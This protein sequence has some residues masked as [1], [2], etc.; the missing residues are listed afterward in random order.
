MIDPTI[1]AKQVYKVFCKLSA[2]NMIKK[3]GAVVCCDGDSLYS[4]EEAINNFY[5]AIL[6]ADDT[7]LEDIILN[8]LRELTMRQSQI[9]SEQLR[10]CCL[11]Q[12]SVSFNDQTAL[13]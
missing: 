5:R 10:Q 11:Q 4:A 12:R 7:V 13:A 9:L 2:R 1:R 8:A 6:T 3:R